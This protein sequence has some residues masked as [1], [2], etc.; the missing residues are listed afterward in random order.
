MSGDR[1]GFHPHLEVVAGDVAGDEVDS[2]FELVHDLAVEH[3]DRV[4]RRQRVGAPAFP[5]DLRVDT[6]AVS[7]PDLLA[8]SVERCR[9][10]VPTVLVG[11]GIGP[12]AGLVAS[13]LAGCT[14]EG[15]PVSGARG[16]NRRAAVGE[17]GADEL[18]FSVH[19]FDPFAVTHV[20]KDLLAGFL[21]V[22]VE[23][24]QEA[25]APVAAV[26][27]ELD[28]PDFELQHGSL[29]SLSCWFSSVEGLQV[30]YVYSKVPT[31]V[32]VIEIESF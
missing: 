4:L 30:Q 5:N 25:E 3:S 2:S 18:D 28:D 29:R 14:L 7:E 22:L 19:G 17:V 11:L 20:E 6:A 26:V 32:T 9:E 27:E 15:Q 10:L 8:Y 1:V 21:A 31:E 13:T 23:S 12:G 24:F 16:V